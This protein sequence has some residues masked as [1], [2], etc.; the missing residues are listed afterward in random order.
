MK[1]FLFQGDSITDARRDRENLN[2]INTGYAHLVASHFLYKFPGEYEFFNRGIGGNRIVDVYARIKSDII[3]LKPDFLTLLIGVNDVWHELELENG[4]AEE[5]FRLLYR[6]LL[7]EIKM[8]LPDIKIYI[9]GPFLLKGSETS[10]NWD[11]FSEEVKK[12]SL[13]AEEIAKEF[14][15]PFIS[16]QNEFDK[17]LT[18][19]LEEYWVRDGVHPLE[20]GQAVIANALIKCLEN[21]M[22]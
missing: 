11:V 17:A 19:M 13:I 5:K 15:L 22:K 14:E 8:A 4:I 6:L 9:M 20:P 7:T 12:R 16:L 18:K 21:D 2:S 1:R 10:E 3:N